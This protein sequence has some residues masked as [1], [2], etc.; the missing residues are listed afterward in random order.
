M[1]DASSREGVLASL[2]TARDAE[3]RA[4]LDVETLKERVRA[5][6]ARVVQLERQ[7]ERERAAAEEAAR[8]TVIR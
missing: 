1:L 5:G 2:E 4:R 6:E 7:R 3:M 8:R